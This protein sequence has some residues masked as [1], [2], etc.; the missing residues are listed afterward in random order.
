[1]PHAD[2]PPL[3][4][5][6]L[7][8]LLEPALIFSGGV[9]VP[10]PLRL[11]LTSISDASGEILSDLLRRKVKLEWGRVPPPDPRTP[12][13]Q[14]L[15]RWGESG[16]SGSLMIDPDLGRAL[17]DALAA[18]VA[19][20]RSSGA[21]S[22]AETGILEYIALE[23]VDRLARLVPDVASTWSVVALLSP[24]DQS[25]ASPSRGSALGMRLVL[26]TG[27]GWARLTLEGVPT[28]TMTRAF[29]SA[30]SHAREGRAARQ[31]VWLGLALPWVTL[32]AEEF[33]R[34]APGDVVLLGGSDPVGLARTGFV[35]SET[36]WRIA[37]VRAAQ[38]THTGIDV[39]V[40]DLG[41]AVDAS[42][43]APAGSLVTVRP[44]AGSVSLTLAQISDLRAGDVLTLPFDPAAPLILSLANQTLARGEFVRVQGEVGMRVIER[45]DARAP[46]DS[47]EPAPRS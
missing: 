4:V 5:Q 7:H 12:A 10:T 13:L 8:P 35:R 15:F 19:G 1:M 30:L 11:C 38:F 27:Q 25:S 36:G 42:P 40:Q 21:L 28:E 22:E 29:G 39:Q 18:D 37:D 46:A 47:A 20:L 23:L 44:I 26:P 41:L 34:L 45:L 31:P 16:A 2:A 3:T 9:A 17:C 6:D 33:E 43:P 32:H 24:W 14:V